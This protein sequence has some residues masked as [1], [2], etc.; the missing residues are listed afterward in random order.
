MKKWL[1]EYE[2]YPN[3]PYQAEIIINEIDTT[4]QKVGKLSTLIEILDQTKEQNIAVETLI[5]EIIASNAI[6]GE[7]LNYDS[8]RSSERYTRVS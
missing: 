5:D 6:E 3:F 4:A 2:K 1:W 8:V 7:F